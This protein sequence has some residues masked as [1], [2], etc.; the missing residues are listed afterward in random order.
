MRTEVAETIVV[1]MPEYIGIFILQIVMLNIADSIIKF[2]R[3]KH[4]DDTLNQKEYRELSAICI[5]L[6]CIVDIAVK[7]CSLPLWIVLPV[8]VVGLCVFAYAAGKLSIKQSL[9]V[10]GIICAVLILAVSVTGIYSES[11]DTFQIMFTACICFVEYIIIRLFTGKKTEKLTRQEMCILA[12][13][14]ILSIIIVYILTRFDSN[15][16]KYTGIICVLI[17]CSLVYILTRKMKNSQKTE[18]EYINTINDYKLQ[19]QYMQ[20]VY[21]MNEHTRRLRH[22]MKNHINTISRLLEGEDG[23]N[24]AK[25]YLNQYRQQTSLMQEIVRTDSAVVNAVINEK[26]LYCREHGIN[27][28]VSVD[29]NI[30]RLSDVEL[31][32]VLGNILDNAIEAELKIAEVDRDIKINV[33]MKDD[34]LDISVKNKIYES[35]LEKHPDLSTTKQDAINHGLGI[36]NVREIVDKYDGYM[37]ICETSE[38]FCVNIRI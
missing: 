32:S 24:K 6:L 20:S 10:S 1:S 30:S 15:S 2:I 21:T 13:N 17:N 5:I 9:E 8:N 14:V 16:Y 23:L 33:L 35:V 12:G 38:Y 19:E 11:L 18:R 36:G 25:E 27:T 37:D 22:D 34:I 29:K 4:Q 28:S 7:I 31:C 26:L 3:I